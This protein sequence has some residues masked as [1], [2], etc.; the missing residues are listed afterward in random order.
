MKA[1]KLILQLF[2]SLLVAVSLNSVYAVPVA[3]TALGLFVGG[4]ALG[5]SAQMVSKQ[6]SNNRM[7][8]NDIQKEIWTN[9]LVENLWKDNE[10]LKYSVNADS[11]VLNGS[12]VHIPK[13]GTKPGAQKNRKVLPAQIT[14]RVDIDLIYALNEFTTNPTLI[15]NAEKV[16]LSYDKMMSIIGDHLAKLNEDVAEDM[17]YNWQYSAL[18]GEVSRSQIIRSTG[19]SSAAY[20]DDATGNRKLFTEEDLRRAKKMMNKASIPKKQ[21][22]AMFDSDALQQLEDNLKTNYDLAYAREVI[23]NGVDGKPIHGFVVLERASASVFNNEATPEI[24]LPRVEDEEGNKEPGNA[25]DNAAVTCWQA[26]SVERAIGLSKF[27][28]RLDDPT[29]FGDVYSGLVRFGGRLR[30]KEGVVSIVQDTV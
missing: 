16:E 19:A 26:G 4:N 20:L 15:Q 7:L 23:G 2:F 8:L 14:R 29:N 10:F 22:Y 25:T 27:F 21:R 30:R 17:L 1:S 18:G 5:I 13:A 3:P 24:L 9:L 11:F 12:L 6:F 28:E